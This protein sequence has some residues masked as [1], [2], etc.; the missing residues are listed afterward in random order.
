[1]KAQRYDVIVIGAGVQG[2]ATACTLARRGARVLLLEQFHLPHSRG[3]SHGATRITRRAYEQD[4]FVKMMIHAYALWDELER[5]TGT[6]LFKRTG[7]LTVEDK[8]AATVKVI[9]DNLR[10][11]G[12][13][14]RSL[15][16]E[17]LKDT[18]PLLALPDSYVGVVDDDAGTLY[19]H[20][21]V[22]C[23]QNEFTRYGGVLHDG[24]KVESI[25]PGR[26]LRVNTPKSTYVADGL[27]VCAGP[28]AGPLLETLGLRLPLQ[29]VTC[30][31]CYWKEKVEGTYAKFPTFMYYGDYGEV[32]GL[33]P[34]EY[35]GMFK[36]CL[37]SGVPSEP[38]SRDADGA[39]L[40]RQHG[41][42]ANFVERHFPGLEPK[43]AIREKCIYTLTPDNIC[44]LDR[45]PKWSNVAIGAGFSGTGFKLAPVV[46][47]ILADMVL[48]VQPKFD[49]APFSISRF[50][51][52]AKL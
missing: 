42:L 6:A 8:P 52:Q 3:S 18:Y 34:N 25:T 22:Q 41:Q 45:H 38:D 10:R 27:V 40:E 43:A 36:I 15:T 16:F 17:E 5:S 46:G 24:E 50:Q 35:P 30:D 1:M 11:Y 37:H 29:P 39:A 48:G 44:I 7:L 32:Y 19:A 51:P 20:K 4:Y 14:Y 26:P 28:W 47:E 9:E 21:A 12:L 31:V 2:S 13:A 23:F 33:P 49:L